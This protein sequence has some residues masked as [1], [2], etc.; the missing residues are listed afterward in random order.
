MTASPT[1][2]RAECT[3]VANAVLDGTD[4]VMLSGETA[5]G[6]YPVQ[7]V[8]TM[9]RICIEAE[10]SSAHTP[11]TGRNR[12]WWLASLDY[13]GL[14][15]RLRAATLKPI[16]ICEAV[17]SSAVETAIDI[18][19]SL[20]IA[21]TDSGYTAKC[22]AKYRPQARVLAVTARPAVARQLAGLSR[23]EVFC[24]Q[25]VNI[26]NIVDVDKARIAASRASVCRPW[27]ART[28]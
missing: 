3:D 13:P 10:G 12:R 7:A 1:P 25:L 22:I 17:A 15:S 8:A 16:H 9:A 4:C 6:Q 19:A 20:I 21:L 28:T 18:R 23:Y 11:S 26:V 27:W 24:A 5:K 14:Y 2:S